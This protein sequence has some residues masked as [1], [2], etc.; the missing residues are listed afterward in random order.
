[1]SDISPLSNTMYNA[2]LHNASLEVSK[3]SKKEK[4]Q[5]TSK[6][7]F[8]EILKT[9]SDTQ[10]NYSLEFPKEIQS[11][12]IEDAAV[13]LKDAVDQAGDALAKEINSR[14]IGEFKKAVALFINFVVQNNY[15]EKKTKFPPRMKSSPMQAFSNYNQEKRP[16][17]PHVII[18][19]LQQDLDAFARGMLFQQQNNLKIL[20][21][22]DE[23]KGLIIDLMQS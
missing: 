5:G 23:I 12:E 22:A 3:D 16:K 2:G 7:K 17:D 1:M 11:M 20:Q 13:F 4:V 8:S 6:K 19:T 9:Q 18:R 21:Q 15:A 14:T 10:N